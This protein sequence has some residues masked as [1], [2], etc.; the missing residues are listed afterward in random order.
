M[1]ACHVDHPVSRNTIFHLGSI[2]GMNG[3]MGGGEVPLRGIS[4]Y[5]SFSVF[6][7][8]TSRDTGSSGD[9]RIGGRLGRYSN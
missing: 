8:T 7:V 2:P 4:F 1:P 9:S 5:I 3:I 6:A